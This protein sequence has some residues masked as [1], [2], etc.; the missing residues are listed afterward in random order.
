MIYHILTETKWN[1]VKTGLT[2]QPTSL[3]VEGYIHCSFEDQILKIANAYYKNQS[4]I[5]ILCINEKRIDSEIKLEN[6]FNMDENYPH[7]YGELPINAVQG[8]VKL[9]LDS[10]GNFITPDLTLLSSLVVEQGEW[11]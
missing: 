4:N 11:T 1:T 6:L 3:A 5:V 2:Y 9:E 8:V 7:V 10:N